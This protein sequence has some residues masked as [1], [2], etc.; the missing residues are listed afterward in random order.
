MEGAESRRQ[1]RWQARRQRVLGQRALLV[2][3]EPLPLV[4]CADNKD[5]QNARVLRP[6]NYHDVIIILYYYIDLQSHHN[7]ECI[8]QVSL[9]L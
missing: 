2:K 3:R 4:A 9:L 1:A 8:N 6:S 5:I 7:I